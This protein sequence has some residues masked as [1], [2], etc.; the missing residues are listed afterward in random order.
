MDGWYF[1][2]AELFELVNIIYIQN[3]KK[4]DEEIENLRKIY[5]SFVIIE[6][7]NYLANINSIKNN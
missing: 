1:I 5:E 6:I 2:K 7:N 3:K 4:D